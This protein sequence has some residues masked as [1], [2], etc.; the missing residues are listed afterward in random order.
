[1]NIPHKKSLGANLQALH[2]AFQP[3]LRQTKPPL[4]YGFLPLVS[5]DSKVHLLSR[6]ATY[7][8]Y[9]KNPEEVIRAFR[10]FAEDCLKMI[11][12]DWDHYQDHY[13]M[14]NACD[15]MA[16]PDTHMRWYATID[17]VSNFFDQA[18]HPNYLLEHLNEFNL[19]ANQTS[20]STHDGFPHSNRDSFLW[21]VAHILQTL[22]AL[23][24]EEEEALYAP[25]SLILSELTNQ[26]QDYLFYIFN[27]AHFFFDISNAYPDETIF[28]SSNPFLYFTLESEIDGHMQDYHDREVAFTQIVIPY[29]ENALTDADDVSG[30]VHFDN[31][32]GSYNSILRKALSHITPSF[33]LPNIGSTSVLFSTHIPLETLDQYLHLPIPPSA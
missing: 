28:F 5:E 27:G 29:I 17:V 6:I 3:G 18:G 14:N 10:S 19:Y 16:P 25:E 31:A 21:H 7:D 9:M 4:S 20:I 32:G 8:F 2:D 23:S 26:Q 1:M 22:G 33:H 30:L 13:L 24:K 12:T 11:G 15:R